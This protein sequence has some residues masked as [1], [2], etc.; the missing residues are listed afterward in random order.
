[1]NQP[2]GS[3]LTNRWLQLTLGIIGMISVTNLQY[4]WTF[5][6]QPIMDTH[7][8]TKLQV[9][10]AFNIFVLTETWLVPIEAYLADLFG[11]RLLVFAGGVLVA[12]AWMINSVADT[13][14]LLYLGNALGGAGAGIVYGISIG[15]ALRWFPDR[16]G[17][18]AGLTAAAFGAGSAITVIPIRATIANFGYQA[19]FFWF[20]IGQGMIVLLVALVMRKPHG[21]PTPSAKVAQST[22]DF[23]PMEMLRTPLFWLLYGMMTL[24][25]VGGLMAIQDLAPIAESFGVINVTFLIVGNAINALSLAAMLDR[26]MGGITRPIFGWISDHIGREVT[27]FI[28][29]TL[30][31]GAIFGWIMLG[32]VPEL[33][34]LFSA[35]TLFF[36]GEIYSLFPALCGDMFGRRFATTNYAILYTAKGTANVFLFLGSYLFEVTGSWLPIFTVAIVFN[37]LVAF[38]AMFVLRPLRKRWAV[39]TNPNDPRM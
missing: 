29:F 34:V 1:M 19:A 37:G 38:T 17:L 5:F 16:R 11:S 39:P 35:L 25:N 8:W 3:F 30:E 18:A 28:A 10:L 15:N 27:M 7:G 36:W 32:H 12:V 13:L 14:F 23:T 22:R 21:I 33:F 26:I 6:V 31:A 4:G 2:T 24:A 20:G 9:Q